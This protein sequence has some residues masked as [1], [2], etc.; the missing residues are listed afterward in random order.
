MPRKNK[1]RVEKNAIILILTDIASK[2][3]AMVLTIAVA[4]FLGVEDFGLYNYSYA[5][6]FVCLVIADFG[7]DR[8]TIREISRCPSRASRFLSNISIVKLTLYIPSAAACAFIALLNS[9]DHAR[10][11]IVIIVFFAVAAQQHIQFL[12]SFFRARQAMEREGMTRFILA[13]LLFIGGLMVLYNG[14]GIRELVF[15]NIGIS[16]FCLGLSILMLK[17]AVGLAFRNVSWRYSKILIK[18]SAPLSIFIILSVIFNSINVVILNLLTNDRMTGFYSA[19]MKLISL[20]S[21]LSAGLSAATLP[22][23]SKNMDES[24]AAFRRTLGNSI[25]YLI[26]LSVPIF[27]G[28]L[29]L[30][31][32]AIEIIY[33]SNYADSTSVIYCLS[34][35]IVPSFLNDVVTVALTSMRREKVMVIGGIL[36]VSVVTI[37]CFFLIPRWGAAGAAV[38]LVITDVMIFSYRFPFICREV[39]VRRQLV[40]FG[41]AMAGALI[42]AMVLLLFQTYRVPFGI[43]VLVSGCVYLF[44]LLAIG[45]IRGDEVRSIWRMVRR[46]EVV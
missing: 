4:R 19:S 2:V 41:R 33:G 6:A 23:L 34:F 46:F 1:G 39:E 28:S 8:L 10:L 20:F 7:F 5:T 30:G 21:V 43:S 32:H 31:R 22:E 14:L 44:A 3:L 27:W 24:P 12:L 26:L 25:R 40:V 29:L 35:L 9:R 37:L 38:A 45:E 11:L 42:M 15:S 18:M 16:L 13:L 17:R 36:G